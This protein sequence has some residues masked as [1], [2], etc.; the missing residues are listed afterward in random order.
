MLRE[1]NITVKNPKKTRLGLPHVEYVSHLVSSQGISFTE[2]SYGEAASDVHRT[3][4]LLPRP[5]SPH[6]GTDEAASEYAQSQI[7]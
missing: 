1:F 6:D 3:S 7:L 5:C 2:A 4:L